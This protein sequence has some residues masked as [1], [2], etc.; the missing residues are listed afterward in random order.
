[1]GAHSNSDASGRLG[2]IVDSEQVSGLVEGGEVVAPGGALEVLSEVLT[3]VDLQNG[4]HLLPEQDGR[5]G[6]IHNGRVGVQRFERFQG[7]KG[8]K[9]EQR[10]VFDGVF[11]RSG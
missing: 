3:A 1:L 11:Q 4:L 8:F 9:V 10:D 6:Q 5:G 2:F 7:L